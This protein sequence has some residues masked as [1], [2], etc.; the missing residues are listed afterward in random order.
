MISIPAARES[1]LGGAPD[2]QKRVLALAERLRKD[3]VDAQIDQYVAGT[4]EEGWPRWML[5]ATE[6]SRSLNPPNPAIRRPTANSRNP[7]AL[8]SSEFKLK[9]GINRSSLRAT[10]HLFRFELEL[11]SAPRW[12]G[13]CLL[14]LI[15][16]RSF[17]APKIKN[18]SN[19]SSNY[20]VDLDAPVEVGSI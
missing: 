20:T 12:R 19:R 15:I 2:H 17:L 7:V 4:P 1:P 10:P 13:R 11:A 9:A 14:R 16:V 18:K 8:R 6:S 5:E 3:G